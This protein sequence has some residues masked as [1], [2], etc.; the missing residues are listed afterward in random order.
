[1]NREINALLQYA[2]QMGLLP[3]EEYDYAANLLLDL[4][5]EDSF[6]YEPVQ[7]LPE[8]ADPILQTL[9]D[10]AVS[11]GLSKTTAPAAIYLIPGS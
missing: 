7:P 11:K 10:K 4:L 2:V 6:A 1:M 8:T 5:G 3:L 9:L